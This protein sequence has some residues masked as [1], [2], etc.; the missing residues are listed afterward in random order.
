MSQNFFINSTRILF[1]ITGI[2][3]DVGCFPARDIDDS[4]TLRIIPSLFANV[5]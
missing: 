5:K 4:I 2:L 3:T 1:E